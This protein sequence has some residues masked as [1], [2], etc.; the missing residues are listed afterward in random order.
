MGIDSTKET[1]SVKTEEQ[2]C[3]DQVKGIVEY[4]EGHVN[5]LT[6]PL[7]HR[8]A[9]VKLLSEGVVRMTHVLTEHAELLQTSPN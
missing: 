2:C 6:V 7:I 5:D 8:A 1:G 3:I 9:V 4:I